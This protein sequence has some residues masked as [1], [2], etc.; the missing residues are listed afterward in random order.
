MTKQ[1]RERRLPH[2]Q[3]ERSAWENRGCIDRPR[4][5]PS[6]AGA[7][8][9]ARIAF[10]DVGHGNY[11]YSPAGRNGSLRPACG[12]A[13]CKQRGRAATAATATA[14][15]AAAAGCKWSY[16]QVCTTAPAPGA[17]QAQR[18]VHVLPPAYCM[19]YRYLYLRFIWE[20]RNTPASARPVPKAFC[21]DMGFWKMMTDD[22]ITCR[23]GRGGGGHFV[24]LLLLLQKQAE[25]GGLW[26]QGRA[27]PDRGGE[28]GHKHECRGQGGAVPGWGRQ[29]G[30][31]LTTTRLTQL[32]MACV[33]GVTR[34]RIM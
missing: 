23:A 7:G 11:C 22:T 10:R 17:C 14:V 19:L 16:M 27:W 30:T 18:A 1:E 3:S 34:P 25:G 28:A 2:S 20:Y 13:G 33:T 9:L 21:M 5:F 15:D 26:R 32:P 6:L 29:Q 12:G 4:N 8:V 31:Q 24:I